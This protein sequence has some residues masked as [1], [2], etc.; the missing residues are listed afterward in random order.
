MQAT[1]NTKKAAFQ[2]SLFIL[3]PL[4]YIIIKPKTLFII[5]PTSQAGKLK[6]SVF[7]PKVNFNK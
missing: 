1:I 7:P 3:L 2:K 5:R 4:F 6:L